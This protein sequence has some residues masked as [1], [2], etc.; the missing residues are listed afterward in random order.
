MPKTIC[1]YCGAP[2]TSKL[3]ICEYC[4]V[5]PRIISDLRTT[6]ILKRLKYKLKRLKKELIALKSEEKRKI[7]L[8]QT[9]SKLKILINDSQLKINQISTKIKKGYYKYEPIAIEKLR[10]KELESEIKV[11]NTR[12]RAEFKKERTKRILFR[13]IPIT[14]TSLG[15]LYAIKLIA[16]N[17]MEYSNY[18]SLR[19]SGLEN[20]ESKNYKAAIN[21]LNRAIKIKSNDKRLFI[22]RGLSK[23]KIGNYKGNIKDLEKAISLGENSTG[24]YINLAIAKIELKKYAEAILD[25]DRA[26]NHKDANK[27]FLL[28]AFVMRG[29]ANSLLGN[30][31]ISLSDYKNSIAIKPTARGHSASCIAFQNLKEYKKAI[32]E[33]SKSISIDS[34]NPLT[35]ASQGYNKFNLGDI[36]G[37]CSNTNKAISLGYRKDDTKW[38][39][40]NKEYCETH[41]N[42]IKIE[43]EVNKDLRN[44]S[45]NIEEAEYYLKRLDLV[46]DLKN[47]CKNTIELS[48]MLIPLHQNS[49]SYYYRARGNGLCGNHQ[50]AISDY[51]KAIELKDLSS[52]M[53]A[54]VF[55]NRA[56][57]KEKIKDFKGAISDYSKAIQISNKQS[58]YQKRAFSYLQL[59]SYEEAIKDYSKAIEI[60]KTSFGF[61]KR[62][63]VKMLLGKY[64]SAINDFTSA[65]KINY[66]DYESYLKR[67]FSKYELKDYT[68]SCEDLK[69]YARNKTYGKMKRS[70]LNNLKKVKHNS[71]SAYNIYKKYCD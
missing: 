36:T 2:I 24:V 54:N 53:T 25:I 10:I 12:I 5:S 1:N 28:R 71:Q 26:I 65:I 59:E 23:S 55:N 14:I 61:R 62:G 52:T 11:L 64:V 44:K 48:N 29:N 49:I 30:H 17:T 4:N 46:S 58:Y 68:S 47:N 41:F 16:D 32:D 20:Y 15:A 39:K 22:V 31:Q 45:S 57:N 9:K 8:N 69:T 67:A 50:D 6:A 37:F 63:E 70:H 18:V 13:Y 35:Y 40:S 38:L 66:Y 51:T 7:L 42:E 3:G 60:E 43:E 19:N 56:S 27:D 33:C 21:D 34:S